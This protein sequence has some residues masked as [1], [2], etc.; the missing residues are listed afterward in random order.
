M[1][2]LVGLGLIIWAIVAWFTHIFFCLK[3]GA[4]VLLI[5]GAFVFP[6]GIIH[7]TGLWFGAW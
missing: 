2:D 4:Y 5:A 1:S 3:T 6:V 7:G